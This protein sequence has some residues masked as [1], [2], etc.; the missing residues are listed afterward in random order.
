MPESNVSL[1][2]NNYFLCGPYGR[3]LS[4]ASDREFA[5]AF[6]HPPGVHHAFVA[7]G[8]D[9]C[10]FTKYYNERTERFTWSWSLSSYGGLDRALDSLDGDT[11]EFVSLGSDGYYFMRTRSGRI[12]WNLPDAADEF[13]ENADPDNN[14]V[15]YVWL[16]TEGSYVAQKESGHS[17]WN[18]RGNYG[19][20]EQSIRTM[21]R[22]RTLGLNL[23]NDRSYFVVFDDGSVILMSHMRLEYGF[24]ATEKMY[25]LRFTE[26][27]LKKNM[28][29]GR[30][31]AC[32]LD[33]EVNLTNLDKLKEY[34]RRQPENKRRELLETLL[35]PLIGE[36][37]INSTAPPVSL[38]P[39]ADLLTQEYRFH[40]LNTY[41]RGSSEVNRWPRDAKSGFKNEDNVPAWCSS[42]MSASLAL[43][44][45]K[46]G[47]AT[48]FLQH[49][50]KQSHQQLLRQ[51]PLIFTFVYTSVLF[52]ATSRPGVARWLLNSLN[53]VSESLPWA[54][55]SHPLRLLLQVMLQL[56]PTGIVTHAKST[57]LAYINMIYEALGKV[58]PIIQDMMSD[59][60]WRLLRYK[61]MSP[62]EVATLGRGLVLAAELQNQHR[63]KDHINLKMQLAD[64][65]L[66]SGKYIEARRT[67]E[68]IKDVEYKSERMMPSLY[69]LLSRIDEAERG[70]EGAIESALRSVVMSME[71]FGKW[72]DWTVNSLDFYYKV[73]KRA[74]RVDEA[75]RVVQDRDLA[76]EKLCDKLEDSGITVSD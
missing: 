16:G 55:S 1:V 12:F 13:V 21:P 46:E 72:S 73:L 67:A 3:N 65:Y 10:Y 35:Q 49:F 2:G 31:A 39:P 60:I 5:K 37:P 69:M 17:Q 33:P 64:A 29:R 28:T 70:A 9:D 71:V 52:F 23:E 14:G 56:G 38:T 15:K 63:C 45:E 53:D 74:G 24:R 51:D 47:E 36:T 30:S 32:I 44:E 11:P 19:S 43:R 48:R 20:L 57:I 41:V 22:I 25:K 26:W 50:I 61:L 40:L 75:M 68:E 7:I 4:G 59:T 54:G 27:N 58:Y 42:V 66:E 18:L 62:E 6:Q 34:Y 76:I 8:E